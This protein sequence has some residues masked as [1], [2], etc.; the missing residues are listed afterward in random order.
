MIIQTFLDMTGMIHGND[1]KRIA[2]DKS[3]VLNIGTTDITIKG[4][5]EAIMP[6]LF[7]GIS[8][9]YDATFTDESGAVYILEKVAVRNGRIKP[10][11]ESA[12]TIMELRI[13]ADKAELER[14]ALRAE[15][16]RLDKI[17]D[18]DSLNFLIR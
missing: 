2:C 13:R 5:E 16:A 7:H 11:P 4:G 3:G 9:D 18:T 1:P 14:D 17:F 8:G 15:I 10:P 12:L 6:M